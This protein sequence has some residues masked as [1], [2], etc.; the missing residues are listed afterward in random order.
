M[1]GDLARALLTG[2]DFEVIPLKGVMERA[3]AIEPGSTVSVTA[4]PT[5]GMTPTVDL[6]TE[7]QARGYRAVPHLSARTIENRGDLSSIIK[8]LDHGGVG[9]VFITGGD[10][11]P[12]G[13]YRDA[14]SLLRDMAALGHPFLEVGITGYPEGHPVIPSDRLRESLLEKQVH[15]TYIVTQMCF[16][17]QAI[18]EWITSIRGLGVTLPIKVGVPGAVDLTRLLSIGARIG[19]GDSMRFL[20]KNRSSILGML[21]PGHYR[22]DRVVGPLAQIGDG[23]GMTG[24]HLFTF[25]QVEAT[26]AWHRKAMSRIT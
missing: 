22:P 24:I 10:G 23:L 17:P 11:E 4:S 25:N 13:A 12:S 15:A 7:L 6:A 1:S 26:V 14:V 21:R 9:Q 18:I 20:A 2:A 8:R 5:R 19:V 16:S 3:L